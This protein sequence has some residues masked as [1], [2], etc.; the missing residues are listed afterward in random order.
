MPSSAVPVHK[1]MEKP[2]FQ[3][4]R[5]ISEIASSRPASHPG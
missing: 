5:Q 2:H 4:F 3:T 1:V